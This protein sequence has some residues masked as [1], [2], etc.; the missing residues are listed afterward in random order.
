[1]L[2]GS[3][4]QLAFCGPSKIETGISSDRHSV[5]AG[6]RATF[7]RQFVLGEVFI[8]RVSHA[9]AAG[10]PIDGNAAVIAKTFAFSRLSFLALPL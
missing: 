4:I 7:W 6:S 10:N 9:L 2:L 5:F 3:V 8:D 1:V